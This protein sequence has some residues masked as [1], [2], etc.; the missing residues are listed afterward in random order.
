MYSLPDWAFYPLASLIIGGMIAGALAGRSAPSRTPED[1]LSNGIVYEGETLSAVTLGN[2]L[3]AQFMQDGEQAFVRISAGRGPLDGI[4]S[5][6]AFYTLA[7]EELEVMQ[8]HGIRIAYTIRRTETDGAA[9]TRLNFFIPGRGQDSWDR[10]EI[11]SE[12]EIV[13][14]DIV[15]DRCVW[16]YGFVGLWPDWDTNA[17]TIDVE[18]VEISALDPIAC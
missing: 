11:G 7:P 5:A 2:G 15:P 16:E 18:R 3:D 1:I 9:G 17:N 4:Q 8:G 10:R 12:F 14:I 13:T 6:G